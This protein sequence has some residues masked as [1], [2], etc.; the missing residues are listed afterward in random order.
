MSSEVFSKEYMKKQK[1]S[2][3]KIEVKISVKFIV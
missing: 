1:S 3:H 2:L